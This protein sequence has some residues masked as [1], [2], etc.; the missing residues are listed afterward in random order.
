MNHLEVRSIEC[1]HT[2]APSIEL[3]SRTTAPFSGCPRQEGLWS[4]IHPPT[5]GQVNPPHHH[6]A[7]GPR[8]SWPPGGQS[9]FLFSL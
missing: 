1:R 3:L 2:S 7:S 9:S 4:Q 6:W 5:K 8:G